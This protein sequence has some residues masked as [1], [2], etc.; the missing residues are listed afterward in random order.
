MNKKRPS[1]GVATP[2][3]TPH[4]RALSAAIRDADRTHEDIAAA[5][6]VTPGA[7]SAWQTGRKKVPA[8]RAKPLADYLGNCQPDA[9]SPGYAKFA[10]QHGGQVVSLPGSP[11]LAPELTQSR[12][13]NDIDALRMMVAAL[14]DV[15]IVH[16]PA[17]AQAAARVL[18]K[19]VPAKFQRQGFAG[20]QLAKLEQ[21]AAPPAAAE[22]A[23]VRPRAKR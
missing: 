20:L 3:P 9:I 10:A 21:R 1:G 19:T 6:G 7:V 2:T 18:R 12:V 16:R 11:A 14:V 15:M 5:I 22:P 17:E 4:S 13:E 8:Q 23:A